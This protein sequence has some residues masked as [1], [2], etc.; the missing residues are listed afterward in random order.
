[1]LKLAHYSWNSRDSLTGSWSTRLIFKKRRGGVVGLKGQFWLSLLLKSSQVRL[2][3]SF[4]FFSWNFAYVRQTRRLRLELS[5]GSP[6]FPPQNCFFA[7]DARNFEPHNTLSLYSPSHTP[8]LPWGT[9]AASQTVLTYISIVDHTIH[10]SLNTRSYFESHHSLWKKAKTIT[11]MTRS[12]TR[13]KRSGCLSW[14]LQ[15]A[16]TTQFSVISS[17]NHYI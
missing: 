9:A 6:A 17:T 4:D 13:K 8:L 15:T 1:M 16:S 3:P 11:S 12:T 10:G 5:R 7:W 2:F 14:S